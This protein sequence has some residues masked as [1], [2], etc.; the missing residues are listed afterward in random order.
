MTTEL[1]Q[2]PVKYR[3]NRLNACGFAYEYGVRWTS[4]NQYVHDNHG[5][6]AG[7]YAA[8]MAGNY[9][10]SNAVTLELH[11]NY[12]G[13]GP[14]AFGGARE[15]PHLTLQVSFRQGDE[16]LAEDLANKLAAQVDEFMRQHG[17]AVSDQ[18]A[19]S[20]AVKV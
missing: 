13:S 20:E 7:T 3:L 14:D 11:A 18:A 15:W 17:L 5:R 12:S 8:L 1:K 10:C 6:I 19:D 16:R 9:A 2:P 4:R